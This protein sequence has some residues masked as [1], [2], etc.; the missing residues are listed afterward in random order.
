[1]FTVAVLY[2]AC[3]AVGADVSYGDAIIAFA[4]A[5][6]VAVASFVPGGVGVLEVTLAGMFASVGIPAE[7]SVLAIFVFRVAFYVIP[8]LLALLL[9]RGA[10]RSADAASIEAALR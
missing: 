7:Q 2:T 9:A 4:V 8:V 10:F 3:R 6:V 1:M 5:I